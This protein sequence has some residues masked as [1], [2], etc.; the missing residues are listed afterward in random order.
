[1]WKGERCFVIGGGPSLKGFDWSLL[2]GEKVIATNRS[3]EDCKA[4]II[5]GLD[6]RFFRGIQEL[7]YGTISKRKFNMS[8]ASKI[9][10]HPDIYEHEIPEP[11]DIIFMPRHNDRDAITKDYKKGLGTGGN[12]G[13]TGVALAV[14]LGCEEIYLLGFDMEGDGLGNEVHYHNGHPFNAYVCEQHHRFPSARPRDIKKPVMC[15]TCGTEAYLEGRKRDVYGEF[16]KAF[17]KAAPKLKKLG[18]RVINLNRNSAL[19]CFEFGDIDNLGAEPEVLSD[20]PIIVSGYTKSYK[21]YA[22]KLMASLDALGIK[23]DIVQYKSLR[24]WEKNCAH[25]IEIIRAARRKYRGKAIVWIDADAQVLQDPQFFRRI[26][27]DFACHILKDELLSGTLYFAPTKKATK[28][29]KMWSDLSKQEPDKWDQQ[30]LAAC[31]FGWGEPFQMLP[32][33]YCHIYD[34]EQVMPLPVIEHYQASRKV[35]NPEWNLAYRAI[36]YPKETIYVD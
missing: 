36:D 17:E 21:K 33:S 25:K 7:D 5:I 27:H 4:D 34:Q 18:V 6:A 26:K 9:W 23:H 29:L 8:T 32:E 12:S 28:L 13:Y 20:M 24:K 19:T 22:D 35:R 11:N 3:Y 30:T 1:M 16:R 31:V 15:P 10:V 14:T 2:D